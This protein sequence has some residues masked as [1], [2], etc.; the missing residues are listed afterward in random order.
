MELLRIGAKLISRHK[1]N[2][3]IDQ[4]LELRLSGFSQQEAANRLN[5]DRTFISRLEKIGE[6]R[7]G[8]KVAVVGFPVSNKQELMEMLAKEGVDFWLLMTD[9]E[10]W[11]FARNQNGL[12]FMNHLMELVGRIRAHD[13]V[14]VLGSDYR[15]RLIE[16]LLDREVV[17]VEL[18]Q[19]P[20]KGDVYVDPQ[21]LAQLIRSLMNRE[22]G[23]FMSEAG[24]EC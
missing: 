21:V 23:E 18:G 12:D 9:A 22:K 1:I 17:G 4:I 20:I 14:V 24:C 11:D 13:V 6:V 7:K 10:R 19:S 16:A 15:I 8:N 5:L 3:I 2:S